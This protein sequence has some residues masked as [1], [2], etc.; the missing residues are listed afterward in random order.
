M[1]DQDPDE[2][3]EWLASLESVL[4]VHGPARAHWLLEQLI[5]TARRAGTHLP[6]KQTT[7]YLNTIADRKS[8]V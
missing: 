1:N 2:T 8:V 7:A 4:R 3:R 5:D 6:F